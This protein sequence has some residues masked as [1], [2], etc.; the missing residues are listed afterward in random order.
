MTR[1][2]IKDGENNKD[3]KQ[4]S[5]KEKPKPQPS[6]ISKQRLENLL[7]T[8]NNEEKENSGKSKRFKVKRKPTQTEKK[9]GN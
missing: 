3:D 1:T 7:N 8:M 9:I 2:R 6:G 4:R 5:R